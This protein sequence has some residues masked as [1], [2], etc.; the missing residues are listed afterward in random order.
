MKYSKP[1]QGVAGGWVK[2]SEITSGVKA[3][4]ISE[5]LPIE[6][7]FGMQDVGKLRI[8]GQ[9]ETKNVRV[10]KPSLGGLIDAYGEDSKE[11]IN[12]VLTL[13][14]EKMIV[15]GK[16]VTA[17]YLIPEGYTLSEDAGGY[18][19]IGKIDKKE[20][21]VEYPEEDIDSKEIPF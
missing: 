20:E 13:H 2:A 11:W 19:V 4:L 9:E 21:V 8:Q 6:G 12:K 1:S 14:T 7:E 5:V 10:N 15:S 3:K 16:R 18:L 17:L